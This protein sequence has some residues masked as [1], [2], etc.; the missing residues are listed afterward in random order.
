[1]DSFF[2]DFHCIAGTGACTDGNAIGGGNGDLPM[3]PYKIVNNF[4][5]AGGQSIIFGGGQATQTPADIEIRRNHMYKPPIWQKGQPGFVGA[6]NG[7]PF[8]V[9]NNFELKNAQRVLFEA[10]V[11]EYSWGGFTQK[12][13]SILLT[14]KNQL[15]SSGVNVCPTC[16]VTDITIRYS[17]IS[18]AGAGMSI[19]NGLAG[20]GAALDG[21]RYSIHDVIIDDIDAAR[22][23]GSGNLMQV[24]TGALPA[25]LQQNVTINHVTGFAPK[26]FLIVGDQQSP[27]RN[28]TY[29][30]NLVAAGQYTIYSTG[31]TGNCANG[32]NPLGILN[33][34]FSP[35]VFAGN[36]IYGNGTNF[37]SSAYPTQNMVVLNIAAGFVNYNNGKGGDYHLVASSPCKGAATD[38]KDIGA[39]VSAVMSA[40]A[41]VR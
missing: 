3:G 9:K 21:Q 39:D 31:G 14:P 30:N 24:A 20:G 32:K 33:A 19:A 25:P 29:T 38:G 18:H 6:A 5:E 36:A 8:S 2:T 10:N 40:V 4:L 22:Y 11:L 13:F 41:G 16:K 7:N 23:V 34:C 37:G 12:G 35:Y 27:M 15:I 28:F 26:S 1:V 17:T